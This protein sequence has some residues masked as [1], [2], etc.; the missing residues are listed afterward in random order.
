MLESDGESSLR[1]T[2]LIDVIFLLLIFFILTMEFPEAEGFLSVAMA[3]EAQPQ[4]TAADPF[5]PYPIRLGLD[6]QSRL[7][8]TGPRGALRS[9][10]HL[11]QELIGFKALG[12]GSEYAESFSRATIY[13]TPEVR[14]YQLVG[15]LEQCHRAG[16]AK[17]G[18]SQAAP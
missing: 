1:I 13:W 2:P 7:I 17:V 14:W 8:L 11:H 12:A 9:F 15:A 3:K 18:F 10:E 5:A 6:A 16:I 4:G